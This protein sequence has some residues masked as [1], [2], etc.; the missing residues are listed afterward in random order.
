VHKKPSQLE[1]D[2]TAYFANLSEE[3]AAAE[4]QLEHALCQNSALIDIDQDE[5]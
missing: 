2:T 4:I 3:E 5:E 1:L